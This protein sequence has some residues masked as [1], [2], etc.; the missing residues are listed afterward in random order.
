MTEAERDAK[1]LAAKILTPYFDMLDAMS[2][3]GT[4]NREV[5]IE[6]AANIIRAERKRVRLE[7]LTIVEAG[8]HASGWTGLPEGKWWN[9]HEK[10]AEKIRALADRS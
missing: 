2:H 8:R 3:T 6:K 10:I 4:M 5:H 7:C 9:S 1:L